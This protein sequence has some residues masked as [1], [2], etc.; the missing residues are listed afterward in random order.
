MTKHY[1]CS[2]GLLN[3]GE[4]EAL[5]DTPEPDSISLRMPLIPRRSS[6][7]AP[8]G[9]PLAHVERSRIK[10]CISQS[11]QR[12][13]APQ[14]NHMLVYRLKVNMNR[15]SLRWSKLLLLSLQ[16]CEVRECTFLSSQRISKHTQKKIAIAK[17]TLTVYVGVLREDCPPPE[18][19]VE[20]R[21]AACVTS[22]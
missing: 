20:M 4:T 7:L 17:T 14:I 22:P 9:D 8:R 11:C 10:P 21:E 15:C 5:E 19:L 16:H 6:V 13:S 18:L 1:T 2:A 3:A 12:Y